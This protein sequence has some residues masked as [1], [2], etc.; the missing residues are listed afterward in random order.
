MSAVNCIVVDSNVN[1]S[2]TSDTGKKKNLANMADSNDKLTH[3][4]PI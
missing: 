1:D 2:F 3:A 4:S